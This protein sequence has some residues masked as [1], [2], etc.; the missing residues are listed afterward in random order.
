MQRLFGV[1]C[2]NVL[3]NS[4]QH[5]SP[6]FIHFLTHGF[7]TLLIQR[8]I[9]ASLLS[10]ERGSH[11]EIL[12]FWSESERTEASNTDGSMMARSGVPYL[13]LRCLPMHI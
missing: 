6:L 4:T 7:I 2:W 5:C 8:S 9:L 3:L 10:A 12:Y 1:M 11:E 13:R